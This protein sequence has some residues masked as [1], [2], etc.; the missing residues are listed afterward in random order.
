MD[1][2]FFFM[3]TRLLFIALL[4]LGSILV[5]D[6]NYQE[7]YA[8]A[9]DS[10][11][12]RQ[13]MAVTFGVLGSIILMFCSFVLGQFRIF[14]LLHLFARFTFE[15]NQFIIYLLSF[16]AVAFWFDFGARLW[17]DLGLLSAIPFLALLSSCLS[18]WIF[19][20]NY[21]LRNRIQ[22]NLALPV[23]SLLI[24]FLAGFWG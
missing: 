17:Q 22:R 15:V 6:L 4:W 8:Q 5:Y 9:L 18:L 11:L 14:A 13:A 7:L 10:L 3:I 23:L 16:A 21:P 1:R 19:D 12:A 20:F 24:I 2:T